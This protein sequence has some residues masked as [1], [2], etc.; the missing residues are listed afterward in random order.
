M[1]VEQVTLLIEG[2][3]GLRR[4]VTS[5]TTTYAAEDR[6]K[7]EPAL[8]SMIRS[9]AFDDLPPRHS[10]FRAP[11]RSELTPTGPTPTVVALPRSSEPRIPEIPMP[12]GR[13]RR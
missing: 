2:R 5:I 12:G 6:E 7:L 4:V 9:I 3:V 1:W 8:S 13:K 11:M 10:G